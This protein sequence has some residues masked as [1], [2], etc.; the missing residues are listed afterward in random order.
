MFVII[1]RDRRLAKMIQLVG[2]L[3]K[4]DLRNNLQTSLTCNL[5]DSLFFAKREEAYALQD[6]LEISY[7]E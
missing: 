2:V 1:A 3:R 4:V 6:L 7:G 5:T